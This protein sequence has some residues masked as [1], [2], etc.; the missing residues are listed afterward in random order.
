MADSFASGLARGIQNAKQMNLLKQEQE[1]TNKMAKLQGKLVELQLQEQQKRGAAIDRITPKPTDVPGMDGQSL[2]QIPPKKMSIAE[3]LASA[4]FADLDTLGINPLDV[5]K[6]QQT[7]DGQRI[8]REVM[9]GQFGNQGEGLGPVSEVFNSGM[10]PEGMTMGA[11]G[12]FQLTFKDQTPA[13]VREGRSFGIPTDTLRDIWIK[14]QQGLDVS[15]ELEGVKLSQLKIENEM[16]LAQFEK[17]RQEIAQGKI[18]LQDSLD[19]DVERA[20]EAATLIDDLENTALQTGELA[21]MRSRGMGLWAMAD[22]S[23]KELVSKAQRFNQIATDFGVRTLEFLM[24]KGA[25]SDI[26]FKT[27]MGNTLS[28]AIVPDANRKALADIL[29]ETLAA[30]DRSG[31]VVLDNREEVDALITR[32]RGT[33]GAVYKYNPQADT[34]EAR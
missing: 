10:Q 3:R 8:A 14:Q 4:S 16:K 26:K 32:L 17:A 28:A 12:N 24:G 30:A 7:A 31:E 18:Q 33:K 27:L 9:G 19:V 1:R 6:I 25:I 34:L 5:Q 29:Q 2:G 23:K 22:P 21:D 15:Q 11:D 13:F 20:F